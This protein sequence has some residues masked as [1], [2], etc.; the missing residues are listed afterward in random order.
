M[1]VAFS[2]EELYG[3][4][5]QQLAGWL[6]IQQLSIQIVKGNLYSVLSIR[7]KHSCTS[8]KFASAFFALKLNVILI[9]EY[10]S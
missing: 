10:V 9:N 5:S 7:K 4:E 1:D 8:L 3:E 6:N 2:V